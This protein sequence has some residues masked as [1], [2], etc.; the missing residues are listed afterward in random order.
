MTTTFRMLQIAS[1]AGLLAWA[2]GCIAVAAGAAAG[3]GVFY[4]KGSL[5][6]HLDAAVK[7]SSA[8]AE[9]V[10]KE[11]NITVVSTTADDLTGVIEARTAENTRVRINFNSVTANTT[12]INIRIGVFGNQA[13]SMSIY[14]RIKT[15]IDS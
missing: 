13:M 14:E 7:A 3:T 1:L 6:G 11:M 4:A 9:A 15:K 2:S 10:L 12:R 5:E 8:A